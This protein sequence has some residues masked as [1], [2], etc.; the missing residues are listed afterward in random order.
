MMK[1][2]C[3]LKRF[4]NTEEENKYYQNAVQMFGGIPLLIDEDNLHQLEM[5]QGIIITGGFHKGNLDDYLIEYAINHSLPL[6]GICQGMQSMALYHT[7]QRL[8]KIE[9]H[10]KEEGYQHQVNLKTCRL[11]QILGKHEI[12]VNTYHY[13]MVKDSKKFQIVGYSS[14]GVVEAV[15]NS[16]HRF[17]IG[18]QWHPE[19]MISYDEVSKKLF[20]NFIDSL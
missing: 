20:Q 9:N 8:E 7:N 13:E 19:R 12:L 1:K 11:S 5:C 2:V 6:L 3:I 16:N 10:H 14:D 4:E 17:Q 18:V 15:E